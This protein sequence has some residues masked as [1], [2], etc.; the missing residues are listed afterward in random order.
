RPRIARAAAMKD[1]TVTLSRIVA[2]CVQSQFR[3]LDNP[4]EVDPRGFGDPVAREVI[5]RLRSARIDV[6]SR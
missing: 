2:D 1:E 6:V 3:Y 5:G 4:A